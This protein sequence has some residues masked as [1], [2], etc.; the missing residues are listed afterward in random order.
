VAK[1][2]R[3]TPKMDNLDAMELGGRLR[4]WLARWMELDGQA[5]RWVSEWMD[6]DGLLA[7]WP[8]RWMELNGR[9]P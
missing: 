8:S 6:L 5:G 4:E 9:Q 7:K 2:T 3:V 1:N